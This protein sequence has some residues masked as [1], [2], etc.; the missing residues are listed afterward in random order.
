MYVISLQALNNP[1]HWR[2]KIR[3][4]GKYAMLMKQEVWT[5]E[6]FEKLLQEKGIKMT[7]QRWVV[8]RVLAES[9]DHPDAE[10]VYRR[11]S[12][13]DN[14]ISVATV[15]RTLAMLAELDVI[16]RHDFGEGRARYEV[17]EEHHHHL[18]DIDSGEVIEFQDEELE[19]LKAKIAE[20]MGFKLIDHRLELYGTKL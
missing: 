17:L 15:Y 5:R 13:L 20:K 2:C 9:E 12:K 11:S 8:L 19:K 4:S 18:I 6:K 1:V 7:D 14:H 10:L 3:Q 16:E